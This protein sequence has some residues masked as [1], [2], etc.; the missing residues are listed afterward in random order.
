MSVSDVANNPKQ[1][2]ASGSTSFRYNEVAAMCQLMDILARGGDASV[3]SKTDQVRL[4]HSKFK[5]MKLRL[6][7][8]RASIVEP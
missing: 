4:V 2:G 5:R 1:P 8:Q 7:K 3:V 6:D